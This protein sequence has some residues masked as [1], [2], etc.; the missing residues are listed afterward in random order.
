MGE[1]GIIYREGASMV[2]VKMRSINLPNGETISYKERTGGQKVI[3]LIHGNMT[4]SVH[5]DVIFETLPEKYKIY[6]ID[7][8]GFGHSSYRKKIQFIKDFSDDVKM[9]VDELGI[10]KF[11]LVGWSLGGAVSQRF[12][13]DHIGYCEK[14]I[15][16]AS[17]SSRGYPYYKTNENGMTDMSKRLETLEEILNDIKFRLV[18]KAYD[19]TNTTFLKQLWEKLIYVKNKPDPYRYKKYLVDMTTQRN[20][21]ECYDALNKF[22]I[23]HHHNGLVSGEGK[24]INM[25]IPIMIIYGE[26]DKVITKEMTDELKEDYG[27]LVTYR[28]LK[29]CGHSPLIDKP[30]QLVQEIDDFITV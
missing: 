10:K 20:L 4:S 16:L 27:S 23:S 21:A 25:A 5:W 9:F 1:I 11:S 28:E 13:V 24:I 2:E 18:Q 3:L 22:N 26:L 30:Q 19:T 14:L 12:C 15:L 8:R 29:Q 6:A 7:L 17:V